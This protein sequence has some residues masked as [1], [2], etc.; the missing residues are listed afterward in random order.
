MV[1]SFKVPAKANHTNRLVEAYSHALCTWVGRKAGEWNGWGWYTENKCEMAIRKPGQKSQRS[2]ANAWNRLRRKWL[3]EQMSFKLTL[4]MMVGKLCYLFFFE[5]FLLCSGHWSW[6]L[7]QWIFIKRAQA[8][9]K[10][11]TRL[12]TYL[13]FYLF[14]NLLELFPWCI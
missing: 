4:M 10:S 6:Y 8:L 9:S 11:W 13:T 12:L 7:G 14:V 3:V 2:D 1:R 5:N